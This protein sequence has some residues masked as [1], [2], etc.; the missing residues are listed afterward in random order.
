MRNGIRFMCVAV[1]VISAFIVFQTII[2]GETV[3]T[4]RRGPSLVFVCRE[5]NDLYHVVAGRM[6][7]TARYDTALDAVRSAP[8]G[9][10][11][12]ILADGYPDEP[13]PVGQEVYE[14]AA[15]KNLRLYVEYPSSLPGIA[16]G[17]PRDTSL[18]RG[19][20]TA[21]AFGAGV[22]AM[23]ILY[24]H[25]CR[26][27]EMEAP[28]PLIVI[29]KV[30]GFDR[31][32]F[33]LEGTTVYPVLFE[34]PGKNVLVS[35]TKLSACITARYAPSEKWET[36]WTWILRWLRPENSI[37]PVEWTPAVRPSFTGESRLPAEIEVQALRRGIDWFFNA[38]LLIHPS[39]E[40]LYTVDARTWS[41]RIGPMPG[42]ERPV[43][44]GSL[45]V[46]EGFCSSIW[47]DGTQPVRWWRRNDCNAETAGAMALAGLAL[48]ESRYR[49]TAEHIC[50]WLCL[51]SIMSQGSRADSGNPSYG[52]FG[53]NDVENYWRDLDGY[54]VY[55]G[56]DN[57][58][59]LLGIIAASAVLKTD[60]WDEAVT[61]CLMANLRTTGT[62]G[63][64]K[65][66]IDEDEL[67]KNGWQSYFADQTI[68]YSPHYQAYLWACYLWA[69]RHTGYELFL[70]RAKTAIAM[71]MKAYPDSWVWTN[72]IQQERARMI[73]PLAWL[74][75]V[76]DTPEHRQWLKIMTGELLKYQAPCGAI[77]EEI[78]SGK[79]QYG[80]PASNADYGKG[81]ASLIQ[82]NGDPL[83]DMLYTTNFAFLGLHEA[84]EATGD[85]LYRETENRL[86]DFL[87]RIQVRS[88]AHPELD[89]AWFRAFDFER[90]EHWGSNSDAGWGV[91]STETGWTQG[92]ITSV[93]ALRR[94]KTSL[95]EL[96]GSSKIG[97]NFDRLRTIM[98]PG[99]VL[100]TIPKEK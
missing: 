64:R 76:D 80:P 3:Q 92:W 49:G 22:S 37:P 30:A 58:R 59:S 44:D 17:K 16:V 91:W 50:D 36:I 86:A 72:G 5:D 60:R 28:H 46:L 34:L 45:G 11:V 47:R 67:V 97:R 57:A 2:Y 9:S 87:C 20:V 74:V 27:L 89:G 85:T 75:R 54:G 98:I 13:T 32:V 38:R 68:S 66:R 15:K 100:I 42:A 95:W 65:N 7:E 39:W 61:R 25:G 99:D 82:Q 77:R 10:G 29:A 62:L 83:A 79:G 31:A 56:D 4:V 96:S 52:L 63:F 24:L 19:V 21:G 1:G 43:G 41:D 6:K 81:E 35:T 8:A 71:T 18:E 93:L 69:Y 94:L 84:A 73:L 48:D 23:D 70:N 26:F 53:W 55:Y 14:T 78:G 90:W 51:K 40:N 88:E 12:L 33:G